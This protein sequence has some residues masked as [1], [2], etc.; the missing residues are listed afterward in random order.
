MKSNK[1][2]PTIGIV[3][4]TIPGAIDCINKINQHS[5]RKFNQ[6]EHPNIVLHQPNFAPIH[7]A[8]HAGRWDIVEDS[9]LASIEALKTAGAEFVIIPANTVHRVIKSLTLR[10]SLPVISMLDAVADKCVALHVKRV[11]I[12]GTRWTM[13]DHLYLE[14]L[15]E[16]GIV[17]VLPNTEDQQIIQDVIFNELIPTGRVGDVSLDKLL[18]VVA[19]LKEQECDAIA[20]ACTELPLV[21]NRENCGVVVL[22]TTDIL[23]GAAVER[24]V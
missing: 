17:E 16:R 15:R 23:A 4:V 6:F 7:K 10:S 3:G 5:H 20:L 22:D 13:A 8:Q 24:V 14:S 21:L 18:N 11:G 19:R 2:M 12:M 1:Q 9:L